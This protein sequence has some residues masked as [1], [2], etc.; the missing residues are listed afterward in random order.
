MPHH[1]RGGWRG[2][3]GSLLFLVP[4]AIWLLVVVVY[5][6]FAT[7]RNSLFDASGSNFVGLNNY[8]EVFSTT[9]ILVTF[10]NNVIWF[11]VFPFFVTF[12][13][14]VFAVLTERVRWS[15]AF[16]TIIF[17]PIVF[18]A[19]ASGLVWRSIFDLDPHI[20]LVNATVKTVSDWVNPPGLYPVDTA[21]GQ[22][23][24]SLASTNLVPAGGA[25]LSATSV[26]RGSS[27]HL[28]F[29]GISPDTLQLVGARRATAASPAPG[30]VTGIAWRDFSPSHPAS[31]GQIF[32]DEQG[33]P[34]LHLTLLRSDGSTVASTMT[35]A[36]GGFRFE[37]VGQGTFRVQVD[38]RNF[39]SGFTGV[40]WL[41]TQSITPTGGLNQTAQAL[42]SIPLVDL[43]MII[44]YL[45]IWAGFAMVVIGAGLA[46]LNREV[47]EAARIDGATE[48]QTLRRV[49]VPMLAPVLVVVFV[50][51]VINVLKIFD[52]ILNMAPG[53]SQGDANTL[54]L[55]MYNYGFTGLGDFGLASA[56]A[57]ILFVLVVPAMLFNLRRIRG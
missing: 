37:N 3:A 32:P 10:R 11:I 38:A 12:L 24:A 31:R 30:D 27:V 36:N 44:A 14:L 26:H 20:G 57:V 6:L 1:A 51:M 17:M 19:T 28:G 48:W 39:Q 56:I 9:A 45:W 41:G 40:F 22:S 16:K 21:A 23:I 55:A 13:G 2:H 18:S 52:I 46:A 8:K 4:G 35:N 54:A 47:L 29:R 34:G 33:L 7:V 25:L 5:P 43:A 50:T 49:T 53:S 42:L 15:T